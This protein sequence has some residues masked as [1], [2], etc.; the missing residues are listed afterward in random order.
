MAHEK[1]LIFDV[2]GG[3]LNKISGRFG[4]SGVGF[5]V[6]LLGSIRKEGYKL[7]LTE[8]NVDKLQKVFRVGEPLFW[9]IVELAMELCIFDREIYE[10]KGVL[11]S[12]ALQ[13]EYL[14][15]FPTQSIPTCYRLKDVTYADVS[16]I[17]AAERAAAAQVLTL[18]NEMCPGLH[19]AIGLNYKRSGAINARLRENGLEQ[20]KSMFQKAQNS[21]FLKGVNDRHWIPSF[22][23]IMRP[24][25]FLAILEGTYD[26][27][28]KE[29]PKSQSGTEFMKLLMENYDKE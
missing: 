29:A 8:E 10:E 4:A 15:R 28:T 1:A 23:W 25:N 17:N 20:V 12:S 11:T 18:Y 27:C 21:P 7:S 5:V 16:T 14:E 9:K 6:M 13:R 26:S 3:D 24:T 2:S 22:D 19:K